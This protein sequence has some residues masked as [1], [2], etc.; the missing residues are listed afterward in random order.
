VLALLLAACGQRAAPLASCAV[1]PALRAPPRRILPA[2]AAWVDCVSLLVGP[3]RIAALP[4]EAFGY[5]RLSASEDAWSSLATLPVFEGERILALEPDLVLVH[6]WQNP[7]TIATL[8]RAGIPVASCSVP[9]SWGEVLGVL[10]HLGTWLGAETS[11]DARI[12]ALEQ[13]RAALA[14]RAAGFSS[15]RALTYTNL[16]A[17]G[18]TSGRRTTGDVLLGLAGLANAAAGAGIDG[19]AP[20]DG[21][22]LLALAPDVIVVG[23]P[24]RSEQAPPSVQFL[25]A[26]PAL[27]QLEAVRL[28]RI[29]TLPP[30]LFTTASPELLTGA[31]RLV[32]ELERLA[33]ETGLSLR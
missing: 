32:D 33:R 29:A 8:R 31:E 21:E 10:S 17:G 16:G 30:A 7:E 15:L 20:A 2:N 3:E 13:R 26:E 14:R 28:R 24:D 5:S 19:D 9:A 4:A 27:A 25:L 23:Q 22:R 12:L 11:A 18:W 1:E 6:A